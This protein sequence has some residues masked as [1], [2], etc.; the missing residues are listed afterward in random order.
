[1][2]QSWIGF[3]SLH[4]TA[5]VSLTKQPLQAHF[6]CLKQYPIT[7]PTLAERPRG[8]GIITFILLRFYPPKENNTSRDIYQGIWYLQL[9]SMLR[10]V[11][12]WPLIET[13]FQEWQSP[14]AAHE[15]SD[16]SLSAETHFTFHGWNR[17]PHASPFLQKKKSINNPGS[18]KLCKTSC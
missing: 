11:I 12:K 9:E 17:N 14:R 2:P 10:N 16:V 5:S 7:A 6:G 18:A 15:L 8:N 13:N 1:M 3:R 4:D